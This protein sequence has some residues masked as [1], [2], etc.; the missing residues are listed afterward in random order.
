MRRG[1]VHVSPAIPVR[2]GRGTMSSWPPWPFLKRCAMNS[3]RHQWLVAPVE[4]PGALP[5]LPLVSQASCDSVERSRSSTRPVVTRPEMS[6]QANATA[7]ASASYWQAE[8]LFRAGGWHLDPD[9]TPIGPSGAGNA[10]AW[11]AD[12]PGRLGYQRLEV[13]PCPCLKHR[14]NTV[15]NS[16]QGSAP[17]RHG[18][19]GAARVSCTNGHQSW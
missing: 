7:I 1:D 13:V 9:M 11:C 14:P 8:R 3:G 19:S 12:L 10:E 18:R 16:Q 2:P 5:H 6:A 15:V 17:L 4:C